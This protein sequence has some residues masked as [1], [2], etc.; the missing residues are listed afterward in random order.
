MRVIGRG[1]RRGRNKKRAINR[2]IKQKHQK[3]QTG[4]S[5]GQ[6]RRRAATGEEVG[7]DVDV[8]EASLS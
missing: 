8:D 5:C 7:V 2:A 6:G 1:S 4:V 3:R